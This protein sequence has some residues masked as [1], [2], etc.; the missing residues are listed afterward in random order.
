MPI[1]H[2]I[3]DSEILGIPSDL[4]YTNLESASI[5]SWVGDHQRI[6]AVV[7]FVRFLCGGAGIGLVG[8]DKLSP[9]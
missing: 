2:T 3:I 4:P 5:S 9:V 8:I 6:S 1:S 7:C